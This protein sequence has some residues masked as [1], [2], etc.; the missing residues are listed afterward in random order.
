M[1]VLRNYR[2]S[3]EVCSMWPFTLFA[4]MSTMNNR[5]PVNAADAGESEVN[6]GETVYFSEE[7]LEAI[8]NKSRLRI[9]DRNLIH[10]NVPYPRPVAEHHYTVK[11]KRR[12]YGRYG[13][14]SGVDPKICWP[15]SDDLMIMR[16]YESASRP[17]SLQEMININLE[18]KAAERK[19]IIL[20][21]QEIA[22]KLAKLEKV[23]EELNA[24]IRK[25]EADALVAK[26]KKDR[27]IE[28]VRRYFG[29]KVDPKDERFKEMLEKKEK[30]EKKLAKEAKKKAREAKYLSQLVEASGKPQDTNS[31]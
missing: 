21:E 19:R 8:R 13:A 11:Y 1:I 31:G 23:K 17:H 14:E 20:R 4:Q 10:N 26:A 15:S 7:E 18:S 3:K 27:L 5:L 29:F 24:R 12:L 28:E 25:R 16:E 6:V 22:T 9:S 30:E 2:M